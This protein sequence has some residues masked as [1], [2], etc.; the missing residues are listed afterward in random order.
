MLDQLT[1]EQVKVRAPGTSTSQDAEARNSIEKPFS[2]WIRGAP[3]EKWSFLYDTNGIWYDIQTTNHA[4]CFN[5]IMRSCHAF[6][7]VGIV[8]FIMYGCMKYFSKEAAVST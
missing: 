8:E 1:A 5:M 6:P 7:L 3:K 2:H 4:E